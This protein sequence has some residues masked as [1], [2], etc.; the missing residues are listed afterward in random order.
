[1]NRITKD[2]HYFSGSVSCTTI[3]FVVA[4]PMKSQHKPQLNE[5]FVADPS[6]YTLQYT[7]TGV[8][9]YSLKQVTQC[10]SIL[11]ITPSCVQLLCVQHE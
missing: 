4:G 7:N 9:A 5:S 8:M 10:T 3:V 1:M 11:L 2:P 6:H